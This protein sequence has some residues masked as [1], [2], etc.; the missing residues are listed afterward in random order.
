MSSDSYRRQI[1]QHQQ[2]ITNFQRNKGQEAEKIARLQQKIN[3]ASQ[4]A[5]R[6]STLSSV[7]SYLRDIQRHQTDLARAQKNVA[8]IESKIAREQNKLTEAQ[9]NLVREEQRELERNAREYEQRMK[10][11][12][13]TLGTHDVLHKKTQRAIQELSQ[14]PEEIVVLFMAAN[15]LDQGQ[16]RLD[17]EA[18]AISE[19]IRKAKHRD[20]V[21][22]ISCWAV[23]PLDLL[24]AINEHR[25]SVIHFSGH[26][27]PRDEIV[28]QDDNGNAKLV[29]KEAIAQTF[30]ATSSEIQLV[31]F[32]TCYSQHQA[33]A[34]V[35]HVNAAIG[36]TTAVGDEAARIF[37][38]QFYSAIGFG[39]SIKAA[40]EQAKAALMLEGIPEQD[41]PE[42]F[43]A[44]DTDA[45][46]L[47]LVK[48][49]H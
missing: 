40:F 14:L 45:N 23:R 38:A 22:L 20:A 9:K 19:M 8:D 43:T 44:Q 41:T 2:A 28:F 34:V 26:G 6:A 3:N 25:P 39:L 1:Q 12:T 7:N 27:S 24:Q 37:A 11:I 30:A 15:P 31:F 42:L 35:E 36:M 4:S 16:L 17:E 49:L 32:N 13:S 46:Q 10:K 18:R 47:I 29:S 48:P 33:E 5:A 21:K